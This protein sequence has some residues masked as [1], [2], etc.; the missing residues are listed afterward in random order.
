M[1]AFVLAAGYGTRLHPYTRL[2][3]KPLFPVLNR[4]LLALHLDTLTAL[5]CRTLVVNAHHLAGQV[6]Q[7]LS[8]RPDVRVQVEPEILG[9]GG[10]LRQALAFFD[11]G[12]I[13]VMN[14][15]IY[16][17]IDLNLLYQSHMRNGHPV[18]MA[19]HDYPRFNCITVR[20][21]LIRD[22]SAQSGAS[23]LAF[24]GIHVV[25]P[26]VLR[27]IKAGTFYHIIDLYTRLAK[28]EQ[29]AAYRVDGLYWRDMGTPADYLAL[30][31]EL[32]VR[33]EGE[34]HWLIHPTAWVEPGVVLEGW[35]C[36]GSHAVVSGG[37]CLRNSVVWDG[38]YLAEGQEYTEAI[39]TGVDHGYL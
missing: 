31:R 23:C 1:Q 39:V 7:A 32:L 25:D 33:Q 28:L 2:R 34:K 9:T 15:D 36:I 13:L 11:E 38:T 18:T 16:H 20:D 35:G 19:V 17:N 3:P 6:V 8:G 14:G 30:H 22:F 37:V 24:T 4:P 10:S 12:P 26:E 29:V 21:G 27:Q 5:G